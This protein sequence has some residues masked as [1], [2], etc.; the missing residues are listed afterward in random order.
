MNVRPNIAPTLLIG[1]IVLLG[2]AEGAENK[3]SRRFD[4]PCL[5]PL[6]DSVDQ[7]APLN[8]DEAF[9]LGPWHAPIERKQI[10]VVSFPIST[11][12]PEAQRWFEQGV[13]LL[14]AFWYSEAERC[15]RQALA[16]DRECPMLYWGL[17]MANER[18]AQR[19]AVF[20]EEAQRYASDREGLS[21][22]ER[23][24][25]DIIDKFYR[26]ERARF[27]NEAGLPTKEER[28]RRRRERVRQI[29]A[30]AF[31]HPEN[32]EV[33][34][35][36]LRQVILDQSQH[37]DAIASYYANDQFAAKIA[38]RAPDH[39]SRH[40]R[41]LL[42]LERDPA[43]ALPLV[44]GVVKS[45]PRVAN[46]WRYAGEAH[47]ASG[48]LVAAASH[49]QKA[50][51]LG[52]EE[53]HASPA[54]MPDGIEGLVS[55]YEALID[56]HTSMGDLTPARDAALA[57]SKLPR[58]FY[59]EKRHTHGQRM[60]G[61][62]A[63]GQRVLGQLHLRLELWE[64]LLAQFPI[65]EAN[66]DWFA[67]ASSTFWRGI[68]QANLGQLAEARLSLEG[69][70]N[71]VRQQRAKR[72]DDDVQ[73]WTAGLAHSLRTQ[74]EFSS[75]EQKKP[76][77][78]V[79]SATAWLTRDHLARLYHAAGLEAESLALI[80]AELAR[81]P[82]QFLTVA[83]YSDLH[84]RNT[85]LKN[86]FYAFDE[87]F[88]RNASLAHPDLPVIG[89]L[90]KVATA[91]K[92]RPSRWRLQFPNESP[93]PRPLAWAPQ[94]APVWNLPD[95]SGKMTS[96]KD[97]RGKP[98]VV[99]FFLGVSCPF[100]RV[101]LNKF[102]PQLADFREAGIEFIAITSDNLENLQRVTGS[103]V[104]KSE[105]GKKLLPFPVFADPGLNAFKAFRAYDDFDEFP[106]HATFLLDPKG[107]ILWSDVGH[108][109]FNHPEA[110]L[111]ET[112][113]LRVSHE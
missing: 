100:C 85:D 86:A 64:D 24:W 103:D 11:G 99:N 22:I 20:A 30:M 110:L 101:Q 7:D 42:W 65:G 53:L 18:S 37:G 66:G 28:A 48:D 61:G 2:H 113:R 105:T 35:F 74:I 71:S 67:G 47:R 56:T 41:L 77:E 45:A 15:F 106:M 93:P 73:D 75:G 31:A 87:T 63:A 60:G 111:Q 68:A 59:L 33:E 58:T 38:E 49:F 21:P 78:E 76:L 8:L 6:L 25:I 4:L 26:G 40:Y 96:L 80:D 1:F 39:P 54:A 95:H 90:D 69:L 17:A 36:L 72:V 27:K 23:G 14:H 88:R 19:A 34:A 94:E 107:R 89:R 46:M 51:N 43:R 102:E 3:K 97:F 70:E 109:P 50:V 91:M 9:L 92:L 13:A 44:E 10:G 112:Q 81:R 29:E 62:Y 5:A 104:E 32:T 82:G 84:F 57:L 79:A 83:N 12:S 52:M 16:T 98:I 55:D 108:S